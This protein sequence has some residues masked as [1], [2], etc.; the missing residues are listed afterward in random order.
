MLVST[1][2]RYG[3]R[4]MVDLAINGANNPLPLRVIAER[5]GISESY[6]EQVFAT[7]RKAGLVKAVR[8]S[9]GGY[10]LARSA[11]AITVEEVLTT[12]EGPLIPVTCV[13]DSASTN[14]PRIE[15]CLTYPLW[16]DLSNKIEEILSST[17]LQD[18]VDRAGS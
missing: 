15:S 10:V 17:T 13:E 11:S 3:L 1:K 14:C 8:G 9:F 16:K 12:L 7:L 5:Q 18:L 2:G 4:S 6:L